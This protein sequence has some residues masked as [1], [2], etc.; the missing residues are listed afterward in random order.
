MKAN[1]F[2]F[3]ISAVGS[4]PEGFPSKLRDSVSSN[5]SPLHSWRGCTAST[6]LGVRR[7]MLL[8]SYVLQIMLDLCWPEDGQLIARSHGPPPTCEAEWT[9]TNGEK[10]T[11]D[12]QLLPRE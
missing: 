8:S 4:A 2:L 7:R 6:R 9:G 1:T 5:A 11:W 10:L 12:A 3:T